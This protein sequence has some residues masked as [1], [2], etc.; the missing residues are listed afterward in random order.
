MA[1]D[2]YNFIQNLE[3]YSGRVWEYIE[4]W[5]CEDFLKE[6]VIRNNLSK[7]H[8]VSDKSYRILLETIKKQQIHDCSHK[9]IMIEGICHFQHLNQNILII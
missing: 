7:Y 5:T 1:Y 3:N 2:T 4:G 8:L 9:N 6:C